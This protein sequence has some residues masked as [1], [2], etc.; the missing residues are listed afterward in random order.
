M[1]L[2][3]SLFSRWRRSSVKQ[4]E[5]FDP[6]QWQEASARHWVE[7]L[8]PAEFAGLA[9]RFILGRAIDVT[10]FN[11]YVPRLAN[12]QLT[13]EQFLA[14]LYCSSEF[15]RD[16]MC[17]D[18]F[19]VLHDSRRQLV[20]QLPKADVIVDLGGS[21]HHRPEGALVVMG[22][23]YRFHNLSIVELPRQ[24]R[25]EMYAEHCDEYHETVSTPLGPVRYVYTSMTDLSMFA[26]ESVDLVYSGQSIEHVTPDEARQ[27]CAEARRIVKPGGYF[28]LDTPNRAVTVLQ[29]PN[30]WINP[31]HKYEYTHAEMARLLAETGWLIREAK[32][33]CLAEQSLRAGNFLEA[34]CRRHPGLYDD[35]ASC[36][37]LY[38]KCQK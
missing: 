10:G 18:L 27:V 32:G 37:L 35:V 36:Y 7:H 17:L 5:P 4:G 38:Y 8:S 2:T 14:Y 24:Q 19:Q 29:S 16:R 6:V 1:S 33:L 13:R 26:D 31:D 11:E 21:C 25:H 12:R 22:Y 20:R 28:C 30:N 9:Y 34:D 23:P 15:Q 3:R